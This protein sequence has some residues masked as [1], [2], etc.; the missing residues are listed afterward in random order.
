[1]FS[2][3][4]RLIHAGTRLPAKAEVAGGGSFYHPIKPL[5]HC[6]I[7]LLSTISQGIRASKAQGSHQQQCVGCSFFHNPYT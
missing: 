2:Q 6:G 7:V 3:M 4:H 1:M 5:Q